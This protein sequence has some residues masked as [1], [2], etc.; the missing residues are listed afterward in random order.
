MPYEWIAP[1]HNTHRHELHLW[2]YRSLP[3]RDFVWFIGGTAALVSLPLI[4]S[5]GSAVLWG[6][7]PFIAG[8][9]W[10]IWAALNK[11]YRDGEI[12][13]TLIIEEKHAAL[14]RHDP[15]KGKLEWEANPYWVNVELHPSSGPVEH[16][17]TLKGGPR[18]VEIGAFLSP[19]ERK[20]LYGELVEAFRHPANKKGHS[21]ERPI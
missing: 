16:Y 13:E 2:P 1:S 7:L 15:K 4:I 18:E 8:A 3:K 17:I 10:A 14:T 5:I 19:P 12:L 6:L 9:V 20:A 21:N 11:S